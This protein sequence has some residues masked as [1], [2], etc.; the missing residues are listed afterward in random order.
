[1]F[2]SLIEEVRYCIEG[3]GS[4]SD[5]SDRQNAFIGRSYDGDTKKRLRR[6]ARE[7]HGH[8][9]EGGVVFGQDVDHGR[10][11]KPGSPGSMEKHFSGIM[12][13]KFKYRKSHK[14]DAIGPSGKLPG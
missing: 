13:R 12:D 10:P 1:M 3:G 4:R 2:L 14:R 7:K 9:D 8:P 5:K 11:S 6:D